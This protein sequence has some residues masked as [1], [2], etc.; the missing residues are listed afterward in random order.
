MPPTTKR[1]A[2]S[3][4]PEP[5]ACAHCGAM[6]QPITVPAPV[7]MAGRAVGEPLLVG[8][9]RCGCDGAVAERAA[10]DAATAAEDAEASQRAWEARLAKAGI[11]PRYAEAD[12]PRASQLAADVMQGRSLYITGGNGT[13]KTHL[14]SAVALALLREGKR[15]LML[16]GIDLTLALQATY[17]TSGTEA[18]AMERLCG[19][20]VL[21]IDDLGKEPPTD[22]ALSRLFAVVNRRYEQL[23]PMVVTTNYTRGQLIDRLGRKGDADTAQ[24][25]VSRLREMSQA[26]PL[27]GVDMRLSLSDGGGRALDVAGERS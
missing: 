27:D 22:W 12:H 11:K 21:I 9:E 4:E 20:D 15:S 6:R 14:A 19:Y 17:G 5:L 1:S 13:G 26:I 24:A 16:T 8:W 25:L 18:E 3:V 7:R 23:A 2:R 10:R